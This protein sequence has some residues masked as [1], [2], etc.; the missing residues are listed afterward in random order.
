MKILIPNVTGPSNIGDQSMLFVLLKLLR[1]V[2]RGA[3]IVVHTSDPK[4]Y[5]RQFP[6]VIYPSIYQYV[7]LSQKGEV[8]Q[9]F[10]VIQYLV[11]LVL[12][13]NGKRLATENRLAKL[14][15]DYKTANLIIF[16]GGGYLRSRKGWS[17]TLNLCLQLSMFYLASSRRVKTIVA[18]I[19]FGPFAYFWQA[20]LSAWFLNIF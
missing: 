5:S 11:Y 3:E 19:S 15:E 18:P 20:K 8:R 7:G 6:Y 1:Q 16:V 2:Y 9:I 17:Q 4:M 13:V 10:R 12:V 14:I